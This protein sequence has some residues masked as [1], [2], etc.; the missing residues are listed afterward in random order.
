MK[1]YFFI[2]MLA[3]TLSACSGTPR[4]QNNNNNNNSGNNNNT[5]GEVT[6]S[7]TTG[8]ALEVTGLVDDSSALPAS[9]AGFEA[10]GAGL[11]ADGAGTASSGSP[12]SYTD[13]FA[14]IVE[15]T[16]PTIN[17]TDLDSIIGITPEYSGT[18]TIEYCSV[19]EPFNSFACAIGIETTFTRGELL[20]AMGTS[21]SEVFSILSS[22]SLTA[23]KHKVLQISNIE[24][25]GNDAIQW[26]KT[27]N[28]ALYFVA[29]EPGTPCTKLYKYDGTNIIQVSDISTCSDDPSWLISYNNEIYFSS[30]NSTGNTRLYKYDGTGITR[31]SNIHINVDEPKYLTVYNDALY[32]NANGADNHYKIF[33]YDHN[34]NTI[35]QVTNINPGEHDMVSG[36]MAVYNGALYFDSSTPS[37]QKLFKY[38]GTNVTQISNMSLGSD[39]LYYLT[40]YNGALYFAGSNGT[41]N[42]LFKY[43]GTNIT[44][45][46]D[47]NEGDNDY[48][49]ALV[50][51]DGN[52]YFSVYKSASVG[53][54][55]FKYDGTTITQLSGQIDPTS[56]DDLSRLTFCN[57]KLY[58]SAWREIGY[59]LFRYDGTSVAQVADVSPGTD[60]DVMSLAE[61]N[62]EIYFVANKA[63]EGYKLFKFVE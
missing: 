13:A 6:I 53:Y 48:P 45:I 1:H 7:L 35:T 29:V 23:K 38:D 26:L 18:D 10:V 57:G 41:Y 49:D 14:T 4:N 54:K 56:N 33:K 36:G 37:G 5:T 15:S 43:D 12:S 46:S 19:N 32:F 62:N 11:T 22:N 39:Q 60:D 16:V 42:K 28:G 58:F 31:I 9:G 40:V 47:I 59:K 34:T 2:V 24:A 8:T 61:F 27:I 30:K 20:T 50:V 51:Y 17:I 55:I 44:Q 25:G 63:S 21:S 3:V 52:L